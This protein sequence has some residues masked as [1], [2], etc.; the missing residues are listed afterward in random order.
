[1]I[2]IVNSDRWQVKDKNQV[3]L[4]ALRLKSLGCDSRC[5]TSSF[6]ASPCKIGM[7]NNVK[8]G[9]LFKLLI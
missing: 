4:H 2:L 5:W 6:P 8:A 1:V 3:P 9:E 7:R